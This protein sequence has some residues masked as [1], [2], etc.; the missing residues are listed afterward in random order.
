MDIITSNSPVKRLGNVQKCPACGSAVDSE[1][2]LCPK[3][4]TDFCFHCRARMGKDD[5]QYQCLN[6]ACSY[7]GKLVC[8]QCDPQKT[9][10]E[11]PAVYIEQQDG[12]WPLLV[13]VL[14]VSWL[15]VW[16]LY[17]PLGLAFLYCLAG[18]LALGLL[19]RLSGINI[20]GRKHT[21][22]Q[23]RQSVHHTCLQCQQVV[24]RIS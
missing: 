8:G 11:P 20:F 21:V 10:D 5:E 23:P 13:P 12:W 6:L 17:L 14:L 7:H 3:C 2:C 19:L 24:K 4:K 22:M 1:A 16:L 18:T 15:V 9:L